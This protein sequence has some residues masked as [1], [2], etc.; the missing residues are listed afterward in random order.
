MHLQRPHRDLLLQPGAATAQQGAAT[1]RQLL[2]PER[3]AEHIIGTIV[4]EAHHGL[5]TGAGREHNHRTTQL[6][7]QPQGAECAAGSR[8]AG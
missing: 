4:E 6:L 2:Q 8:L 5:G 7:P 3:F 1:G